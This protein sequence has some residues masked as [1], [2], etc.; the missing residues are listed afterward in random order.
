MRPGPGTIARLQAAA[1]K[2][3][4]DGLN[5]NKN[6]LEFRRKN[7]EITQVIA[8]LEN[9]KPVLESQVDDALTPVHIW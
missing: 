2:A 1:D 6:N 8:R 3:Q 7:Y 4:R 5:G 9:G